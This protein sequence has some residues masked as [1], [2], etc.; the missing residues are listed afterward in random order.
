MFLES[1]LGLCWA[2]EALAEPGL[3]S[4][5]GSPSC[6]PKVPPPVCRRFLLLQPQTDGI[7]PP[8]AFLGLAGV[9]SKL[10]AGGVKMGVRVELVLFIGGFILPLL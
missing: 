4:A 6:L 1:L 2:P 7:I 3:P 9:R 8:T 5:K 10:G